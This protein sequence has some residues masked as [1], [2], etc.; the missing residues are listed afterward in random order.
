MFTKGDIKFNGDINKLRRIN[1]SK[2]GKNLLLINYE[3]GVVYLD[4]E[5][6]PKVIVFEY[7]ISNP[8]VFADVLIVPGHD[9]ITCYDL[10]NEVFKTVSIR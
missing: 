5:G 6:T 4:D 10:K 9:S 3:E 7:E 8:L 1:L 2:K